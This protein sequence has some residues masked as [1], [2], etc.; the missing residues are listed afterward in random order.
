MGGLE[1]HGGEVW[2][3]LIGEEQSLSTESLEVISLGS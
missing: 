2:W 3:E 1:E